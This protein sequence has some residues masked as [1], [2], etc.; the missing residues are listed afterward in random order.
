MTSVNPDIPGHSH[1]IAG[2]TT[3]NDRHDHY[4]EIETGPEIEADG[5]HYHYYSGI[6][7]YADGH[8]HSFNG[9]TSIY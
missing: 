2:R 6:T 8:A 7:R 9:F 5:G 4:Y 1:Y 3:I